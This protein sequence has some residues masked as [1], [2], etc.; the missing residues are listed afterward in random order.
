MARRAPERVRV[1]D[2]APVIQGR[3]VDPERWV[4]RHHV[5]G[6]ADRDL[7]QD[8]QREDGHQGEEHGQCHEADAEGEPDGIGVDLCAGA[9]RRMRNGVEAHASSPRPRSTIRKYATTNAAIS[10]SKIVAAA[11]AVY[12]SWK[13][14]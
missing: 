2:T 4:A 5:L 6:R 13:S 10:S 14:K 11:E 8:Q 7:Q 12:W 9:G 1:E 3:V